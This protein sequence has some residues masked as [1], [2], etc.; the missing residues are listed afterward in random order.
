MP[1][2][3]FEFESNLDKIIPRIE[4][5]PHK[6][7]NEVG[8]NVAREARPKV[9]HIRSGRLKKSLQYWARKREMDLQIGFKMFYAPFLYEHNDP[10]KPVVIKNKDLIQKLLAKALNEIGKRGF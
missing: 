8:R 1:R 2:K 7:L 3:P 5:A 10:I 9:K 6:V 4:K